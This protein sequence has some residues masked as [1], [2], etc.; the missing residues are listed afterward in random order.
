MTIVRKSQSLA[1]YEAEVSAL[2]EKI[3]AKKDILAEAESLPV[4]T[5]EA[6]ARMEAAVALVA[7]RKPNLGVFFG[8]GS[9]R[10]SLTDLGFG[11]SSG[12]DAII[13]LL[14]DTIR[15]RLAA[16]I[17]ERGASIGATLTT[18]QRLKLLK[19]TRDGIYK[20]ECSEESLI[21][22]AET[23]GW[24]IDRREDADPRAVLAGTA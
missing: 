8:P 20:L 18:A 24:S 15:E 17:Q 4:S 3:A 22:E 12:T 7:D 21:C 2:R 5:E 23:Q 19:E 6:L 11:T 13:W 10:C 9:A 1:E 16:E 14:A